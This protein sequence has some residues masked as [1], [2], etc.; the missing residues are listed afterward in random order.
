MTVSARVTVP[1]SDE[2]KVSVP[3]LTAAEKVA[4]TACWM[5]RLPNGV[6]APTESAKLT[7]PPT[8]TASE[9]GPLRGPTVWKA[10]VLLAIVSVEPEAMVVALPPLPTTILPEEVVI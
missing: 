8:E 10:P 9:P 1:V 3:A 6:V 4:L 7:P 2:P 5:F